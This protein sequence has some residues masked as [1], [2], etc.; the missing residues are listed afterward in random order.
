MQ[1]LKCQSVC[2]W[3][4]TQSQLLLAQCERVEIG[5]LDLI[6]MESQCVCV[7]KCQSFRMASFQTTDDSCCCRC[8]GDL[9]YEQNFYRPLQLFEFQTVVHW[10]HLFNQNTFLLEFKCLVNV[11]LQREYFVFCHF[12][13]FF[14]W[15]FSVIKSKI[16]ENW[17]WN[18]IV[19]WHLDGARCRI[20]FF[21]STW[22]ESFES[23]NI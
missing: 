7:G 18:K 3:T 23:Q 22:I 1:T 2:D 6:Y 13:C 10:S 4:K 14:F 8:F 20:F 15:S 19:K 21:F 17:K 5:R 12:I 11:F 9:S 16:Y